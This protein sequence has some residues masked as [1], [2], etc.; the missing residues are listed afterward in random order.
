MLRQFELTVGDLRD[1]R[2]LHRVQ[3]GLCQIDGLSVLDI[4]LATGAVRIECEDGGLSPALP[5]AALRLLEAA[6]PR[7]AIKN[8]EPTGSVRRVVSSGPV[9][10]AAVPR[11]SMARLSAGDGWHDR[12][13]RTSARRA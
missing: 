11:R 6:T 12:H 13:H 3:S 8:G 9:G 10:P 7:F 5:E 2:R 4:N 1:W